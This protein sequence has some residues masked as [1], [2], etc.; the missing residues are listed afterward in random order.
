M[1]R[2][3]TGRH[4]ARSCA[5]VTVP[6]EI[7]GSAE[8]KFAF[9][10]EV[11]LLLVRSMR[12]SVMFVTSFLVA[13]SAFG[14]APDAAQIDVIT[15]E[16]TSCY[17]TCP[18]YKL[19]VRRDGAVQYEG[20]E[21]VKVIGYQSHRI[22]AAKFQELAQEVQRVGFFSFDDEYSYKKNPGGSTSFVTDMPTTITTV[23]AGNLRK[24]VKNYY[25]GPKA[26]GRLENLIDKLAGSA[27]WTGQET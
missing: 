10:R 9:F 23:R 21:F 27:V 1:F 17:G 18:I 14:V 13:A 3:L 7:P 2:K 25:G 19:T 20:K 15:L 16:R 12:S 11:R 24:S 22:S 26:L 5:R 4:R 8:I 6:L